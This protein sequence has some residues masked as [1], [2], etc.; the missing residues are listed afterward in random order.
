M[1]FNVKK[2][3]HFLKMR[4]VIIWLIISRIKYLKCHFWVLFHVQYNK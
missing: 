3:D 2:R 4:L 1:H